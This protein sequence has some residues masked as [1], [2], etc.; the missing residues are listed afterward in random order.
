MELS[1]FGDCKATND[2]GRGR[3]A[4]KRESKRRDRWRE[5]LAVSELANLCGCHRNP[6][7]CIPHTITP[8]SS[9]FK[10]CAGARHCS[11]NLRIIFSVRMDN[12]SCPTRTRI[13]GC[14][15]KC[16]DKMTGYVINMAGIVDRLPF[17]L[18][19]HRNQGGQG[20]CCTRLTRRPTIALDIHPTTIS[21]VISPN[22]FGALPSL[23]PTFYLSSLLS[24]SILARR[25]T[26]R[27]E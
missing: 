13:R 15:I 3:I 24:P 25:A 20:P 1:N 21:L 18:Q 26:D 23:R 12:Q 19:K 2:Q 7:P 27:P 8:F 9:A 10:I 6:S 14:M 17:Q 11:A 22:R 5:R 4:G 16:T